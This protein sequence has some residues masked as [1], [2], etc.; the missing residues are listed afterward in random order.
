MHV[1]YVTRDQNGEPKVEEGQPNP[2]GNQDVL[3]YTL[4]LM[5][6]VEV[7]TI[8]ALGKA[9]IQDQIEFD[10]HPNAPRHESR[11]VRCLAKDLGNIKLAVQDLSSL[12]SAFT[13]RNPQPAA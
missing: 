3:R 13:I 4:P 8:K 2:I 6:I 12:K 9:L 1:C 5:A 11:E 7:Q 10:L